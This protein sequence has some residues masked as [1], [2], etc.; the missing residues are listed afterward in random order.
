MG[1]EG[2][3]KGNKCILMINASNGNRGVI[4]EAFSIG[5]YT[6]TYNLILYHMMVFG[7]NSGL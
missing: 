3:N 5:P 2:E 6:L 4:K 1:I 7:D